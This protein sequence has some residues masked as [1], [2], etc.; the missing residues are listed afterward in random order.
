MD[1]SSSSSVG[2]GHHARTCTSKYDS[3]SKC[4]SFSKCVS[5]SA[6]HGQVQPLSHFKR[7]SELMNENLSTLNDIF[8]DSSLSD[9]TKIRKS[10]STVNLLNRCWDRFQERRQQRKYSESLIG[11]MAKSKSLRS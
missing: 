8:S 7:L 2:D 4:A 3:F 11:T 9:A 6:T 5:F 10:R 1:F